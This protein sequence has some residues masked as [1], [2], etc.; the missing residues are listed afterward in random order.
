MRLATVTRIV[1]TIEYDGTRYYGFQ[2]Q[3]ELPTIQ[4]ELETALRKLSGEKTR[5][6]S[7]SRTDTG[8]HARGQ[9]VSFRTGSSLPV[10]TFVKGLNYYLPDDIAVK[11]ACGVDDSFD[12]RRNAI[13]REYKYYILNSRLRSPLRRWFSYPVA[14][15][16]DIGA[17]DKASQALIGKHDFASFAACS[18]MEIKGTIRN[19]YRAGVEKQEDMVVF[20]VAADSFLRHQVRNTVGALIRVGLSK[21]T[22][23]E[24]SQMVGAETPGLAGPMVPG[25]GLCLMQV[26]YPS[27]PGA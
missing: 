22:A 21:M 1:L 3:A 11:T 27:P 2:L 10:D 23:D 26:N 7:A 18:E 17:M 13:S 20:D 24:F 12:V 8:V 5:V 19:I 25:C 9:V 14:G 4:A 6:M 15:E 16:L